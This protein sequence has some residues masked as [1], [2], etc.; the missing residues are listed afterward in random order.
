MK[1]VSCVPD[2]L[3]VLEWTIKRPPVSIHR[4]ATVQKK[5]IVDF[6]RAVV[7]RELYAASTSTSLFEIIRNAFPPVM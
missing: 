5:S 4:D 6:G 7:V 2:E 3:K 1:K